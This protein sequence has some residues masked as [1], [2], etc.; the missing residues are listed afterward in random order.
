MSRVQVPYGPQ[1][2]TSEFIKLLQAE[3]PNDECTVCISNHP[4]SWI[5][6][7]PYY[8]DGRL[9]YIE[10]DAS[11]TVLK[12]GYKAGGM[13]LKIHYDTIEDVLM[14][15]PD[16]EWELSGVTYKG[17]VEDRHTDYLK[18]CKKDG[19]EFEEWKA[20]ADTAKAK[21]LPMPDIVISASPDSLQQR[22]HKWLQT[23]G[24]IK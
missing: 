23:L 17:H 5:E 7:L 1:M 16:A 12:V 15:Y 22:M 2:K 14:D 11:G 20:L 24:L 9:E 6:K 4:V 3:D 10:K 8:Y 19:K 18:A 21:G 13:K